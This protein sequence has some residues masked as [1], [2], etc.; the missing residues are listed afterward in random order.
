[1]SSRLPPPLTLGA[2]ALSVALVVLWPHWTTPSAVLV[3][4]PTLDSW[5]HAWGAS[6]FAHT[7]ASGK[8]PWEITGAAWDTRRVLW[9]IDPLGATLTLPA[10]LVAGPVLAYNLQLGLQVAVA[11]VGGALFGRA[12]GGRG[13]LAGA[14]LATTP[15]LQGELWNGVSEAC[16]VGLVAWAGALAA[17]RS[18]WSGVAVGLA[19]VATPYL[20][21]SAAALTGALL[22]TGGADRAGTWRDRL[23]DTGL[24]AALSLV[25]VAPHVALLQAAMG[26]PESFVMR[27][28]W[29]GGFNPA[30]L[31]SNAT[32]PLAFVTPG[33]FW[34]VPFTGDAWS[35][36]WKRTP[37]LGLGLLGLSA[38]SLA[39]APRRWP[40]LL[41]VV[42]GCLAALGPFLWHDGGWV[43]TSTGGYYRL[44]LAGVMDAVGISFDHPMRFAALAVVALAGL[45]DAAVGRWGLLLAPLLMAE[46]LVLAP[47]S[48]PLAAGQA[49]LPA[50]YAEIPDDGLAVVDLPAD[51]GT[52]N[53]TNVYLLYQRLHGHPVPWGNKVGSMGIPT[54]QPALKAWAV[55]SRRGGGYVEG[56]DPDADL[57]AAVRDL[58]ERGFGWVVLHPSLLQEPGW[59]ATHV[60]ELTALLGP[61]AEVEGRLLW[62]LPGAGGAQ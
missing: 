12:L 4:H 49:T 36:H 34:S 28:L 6:W 22:L 3:G 27:P 11:A 53:R 19:G 54:N 48:W 61:P 39:R 47:N 62:R 30:V 14:A 13:W 52:G 26:S 59:K 58:V 1:M 16:W 44:P 10:H 20:G 50:V 46:Q 17:R 29:W 2:F 33:D 56:Y 41:P 38:V 9:Y 7:L 18:R 51:A 25:V 23:V 40:L 24:A 43:Q 37:Y 60:R 35:V 15:L 31:R 32:D 45:A 57:D 42:V 21:L 5:S 55:L 8:L